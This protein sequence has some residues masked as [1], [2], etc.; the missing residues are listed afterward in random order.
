MAHIENEVYNIGQPRP[1]W[2]DNKTQKIE[3]PFYNK[4]TKVNFEGKE[5]GAKE[6][7]KAKVAADNL[8]PLGG[9]VSTIAHMFQSLSQ[10]QKVENN[11]T[12]RSPVSKDPPER[13]QSPDLYKPERSASL[14]A[15]PSSNCS[16]SRRGS[17]LA[18]FNNA[19]AMFEKLEKNKVSDSRST[20]DVR[21]RAATVANPE[22]LKVTHSSGDSSCSRS[23]DC[24]SKFSAKQIVKSDT[25]TKVTTEAMKSVSKSTKHIF[26]NDSVELNSVVK[27]NLISQETKSTASISNTCDKKPVAML[28]VIKSDSYSNVTTEPVKPVANLL[29]VKLDP[30]S[31]VTTESVKPVGKLPVVK[32]DSSSNVMMEQMKTDAN[33]SVTK[34]DSNSNVTTETVK[35]VSQIKNRFHKIGLE[36]A[37]DNKLGYS[38]QV[39]ENKEKTFPSNYDVHES[40]KKYVK[41]YAFKVD[42][43]NVLNNEV[44]SLYGKI[45]TE[46]SN[47]ISSNLSQNDN[48]SGSSLANCDPQTQTEKNVLKDQVSNSISNVNGQPPVDSLSSHKDSDAKFEEVSK[49]FSR[50]EKVSSSTFATS[51]SKKEFEV[52]KTVTKEEFA[53][54]SKTS[55]STNDKESEKV[56]KVISRKEIT[57][58]SKP[59]STSNGK[60]IK[61]S[62]KPASMP[63]QKGS[64][65]VNKIVKPKPVLNSSKPSSMLNEK[66]SISS[67]VELVYDSFQ[68][69]LERSRDCFKSSPN[70]VQENIFDKDLTRKVVTKPVSD[71]A[72]SAL[73]T[74]NEGLKLK[75]NDQASSK[76]KDLPVTEFPVP[77]KSEVVPKFDNDFVPSPRSLEESEQNIPPPPK[78]EAP[79]IPPLNYNKDKE[80]PDSL[81]TSIFKELHNNLSQKY[82]FEL[83]EKEI[84]FS[85]ERKASQDEFNREASLNTTFPSHLSDDLKETFVDDTSSDCQY[86]DESSNQEYFPPS[87]GLKTN[88]SH[89]GMNEHFPFV[90]PSE[91]NKMKGSISHFGENS[92]RVSSKSDMGLHD[93]AGESLAECQEQDLDFIHADLEDLKSPD[94]SVQKS[95][96]LEFIELMTEDEADKLLSS[97]DQTAILSDDEAREVVLLLSRSD[98]KKDTTEESILEKN[99][100]NSTYTANEELNSTVVHEGTEYHILQDGHYYFEYPGLTLP[101]P[102]T[103]DLVAEKD[104]TDGNCFSRK[105]KLSFSSDPIR[106]YSTHSTEDYD[107]RNEDV[108][109]IS[110]SAEYELEKRIEKMDVFPV[111]LVKGPEGLGL[112]IIGM[113]VGADAGVEKLG[114]FVKTVTPNGA[115][116]KDGRIH[117]NDQIIEV[118]GKSLVGVTQAYAAAVLRNT[119]GP[120]RFVI[121]R[122]KAGAH[123][124]IAQLI[125]QSIIADRSRDAFER[126]SEEL[127]FNKNH[128]TSVLTEDEL[129]KANEKLQAMEHMESD[130]I[131]WLD[132]AQC[133]LEELGLNLQ[134]AEQELLQHKTE[135]DTL[136]ATHSNVE[137]KYSKA[138]HYIKEFQK[139]EKELIQW[140]EYHVQQLQE[141]DQEYNSLVK[142]LK[143]RII[144]LEQALLETQ[145]Q[146]GLQTGLPYTTPLKQFAPQS[147]SAVSPPRFLKVLCPDVSDSEASDSELQSPFSPDDSSKR[148]STLERR[149][150]REIIFDT[151]VPHTELL[152]SSAAKAKAELA[153]KGS[154]AN[155]QP[156]STKK[157]SLSDSSPDRN[158]V[159]DIFITSSESVVFQSEEKSSFSSKDLSFEGTNW[160]PGNESCQSP[161]MTLLEEMKVA[162]AARQARINQSVTSDDIDE[163]GDDFTAESVQVTSKQ[164]SFE[165][166]SQSSVESYSKVETFNRERSRSQSSLYSCSS[167]QNISIKSQASDVSVSDHSMSANHAESCTSLFSNES[168]SENPSESLSSPTSEDKRPSALLSE[169]THQWSAEQ[170]A[171]WLQSLG[172]DHHVP[173][174][175]DSDITG[176]ILLQ[177][178]SS[179]LKALGVVSSSERSIIKK[180]VKEMRVQL[181]KLQKSYEKE[182]KLKDKFFKR[183]SSKK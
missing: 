77:S 24:D 137:K 87:K 128:G 169:P 162:V 180:R 58:Y 148:S 126:E 138:K 120:V 115:A 43:T 16:L 132:M 136:K 104:V 55:S 116:D 102:E 59:E 97:R 83:P 14:P 114:I 32:S 53:T 67:E 125:S 157:Q 155:R 147:R 112:S 7:S 100:L 173:Q 160:E 175:L 66:V 37:S 15:F 69:A 51:T 52:N 25:F 9:K 183:R 144:L 130:Y 135:L 89:R 118:D 113:G 75:S 48:K 165:V 145:K 119:A 107:R 8:R 88:R 60:D 105:G 123:S 81:Y 54:S 71:T 156:P 47:V 31:N 129:K 92:F 57:N 2:M 164:T 36:S 91:W 182:P 72:K 166:I 38:K 80:S 44:A 68:S 141:K 11:P 178:D 40:G 3:Q 168:V 96:S 158:S 86:S 90:P 61:N 94:S 39:S 12:L 65:E 101:E 79:L 4:M 49:I 139:K 18:R 172:Y 127:A 27:S 110:A 63:T 174:F 76:S 111:D 117:V 50:K 70:K 26:K 177:I 23:S 13:V 124:E 167:Q 154:L 181:E 93:S 142:A 62:L 5:K 95:D 21:S 41:S 151:A 179:R 82:E 34:S 20:I 170:V 17:H 106:V 163:M 85:Q 6:S 22:S 146:A 19:K 29:V 35:S 56:D 150:G 122:E 28:P 140:Q 133:Q 33:I 149:P 1:G 161:P 152:D 153:N 42:A 45:N 109:P 134:S 99:I 98:E 64:E 108:D 121:G 46:K 74:A 131:K 78:C 10:Q 84:A 30:Y 171:L 103:K 143:D 73:D 176:Q 159:Y